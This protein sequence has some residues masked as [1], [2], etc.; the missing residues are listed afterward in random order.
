MTSGIGVIG[1]NI[2]LSVIKAEV[3]DSI[4]VS[5]KL[6][7]HGTA[8]LC[9]RGDMAL[10]TTINSDC[11]PLGEFIGRILQ[12]APEIKFLR[13]PTR[14][15]VA[16]VL[17]EIAEASNV[18]IVIDE[19]QTPIR[20]EVNGFCE[21]LGLDPLYLANEGRIVAVVPEQATETVLSAMRDHELGRDAVKIG[22][23]TSERAGRVVM[24]TVFGGQ[25]IVDMLV[26]EQ[27]PRIC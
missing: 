14:G 18:G 12:V 11:A 9:A 23:V 21:I 10:S 19:P 26:G 17:N 7:D 27:L 16:S 6:G 1:E 20:E 22:T 2:D 5:G 4:L 25:R 24:N 15:G 13:D 3:G 8:I